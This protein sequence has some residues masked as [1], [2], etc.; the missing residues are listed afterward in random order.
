M[1]ASM[2]RDL[3][4]CKEEYAHGYVYHITI[5]YFTR[6]QKHW[7]FIFGDFNPRSAEDYKNR[8]IERFPQFPEPV[9][10]QFILRIFH[11]H[12]NNYIFDD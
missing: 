1:N 3:Y 10:H 4:A 9:A 12:H 2:I 11:I 8:R 7:L 5:T 6:I